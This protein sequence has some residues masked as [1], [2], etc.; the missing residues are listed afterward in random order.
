[1]EAEFNERE[2]KM[3]PEEKWAHENQRA[4]IQRYLRKMELENQKKVEAAREAER[5]KCASE[6]S[7]L[8][9]QLNEASDKIRNME[10]ENG[11]RE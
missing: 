10:G 1:M 7:E 4:T 11:T 2:R 6:I 9:Q 5:K 8:K 3:T